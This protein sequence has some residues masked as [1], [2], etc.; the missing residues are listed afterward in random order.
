MEISPKA[1][2][3][4][5]DWCGPNVRHRPTENR[6]ACFKWSIADEL[7]QQGKKRK[8]FSAG[9]FVPTWPSG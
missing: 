4:M 2:I 6:G 1:L 8:L 3:L 9:K 5:G 7:F